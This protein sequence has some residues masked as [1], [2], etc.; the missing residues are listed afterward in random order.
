MGA[1]HAQVSAPCHPPPSCAHQQVPRPMGLVLSHEGHFWGGGLGCE[2]PCFCAPR[3][4]LLVPKGPRPQPR[5]PSCRTAKGLAHGHCQDG[6][7]REPGE[8]AKEA[9][10]KREKPLC[11]EEH[12]KAESAIT[13]ANMWI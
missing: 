8:P 13:T 12:D 9:K 5:C 11:C 2:Q 6:C 10:A 3:P 4:S 7:L 1:C